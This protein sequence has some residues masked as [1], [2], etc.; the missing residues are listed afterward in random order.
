MSI[1]SFESGI[2]ALF[3]SDE[4]SRL[5]IS[6][7]H[8]KDGSSC[9]QWEYEVD[10]FLT[11]KQPIG[12]SPF[13]EGAKVRHATRSLFGFITWCHVMDGFHLNSAVEYM[14]TV[15]SIL[16]L[17]FKAGEPHGLLTSVICRERRIQT[18]TH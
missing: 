10:S 13:Q 16:D 3:S 17:I 11:V 7:Q 1:Y 9:L 18:W 6:E 4:R 14:S 2:P 5:S 8:Y 12:Y 15:G